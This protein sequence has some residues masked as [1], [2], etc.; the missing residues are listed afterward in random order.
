[1]GLKMNRLLSKT[2][3][4]RDRPNSPE[5]SQ[6]RRETR[7]LDMRNTLVLLTG[8]PKKGCP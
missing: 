5:F 1:M 3:N 4:S 7:S 8:I 6:S 2:F